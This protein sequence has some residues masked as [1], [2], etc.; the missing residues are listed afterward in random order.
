MKEMPV[1]IV[2]DRKVLAELNV[3]AL[4]C[5][6]DTS[7]LTYTEAQQVLTLYSLQQYFADHGLAVDFTLQI[8]GDNE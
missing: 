8:V 6:V 3:I 7:K 5:P 4:N 2:I 1:S